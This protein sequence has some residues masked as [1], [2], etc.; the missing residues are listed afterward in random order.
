[1][2]LA[3]MGG[4]DWNDGMNRVG[5]KGKGESVWLSEF[6]VV[7][8]EEYAAVSPEQ[9]DAAWLRETANAFRSAI[10]KSAWDGEWYLRAFYDDGTPLG[11]RQN[12]EC[13]IDGISQAWAVLAGLDSARCRSAMNAAWNQL[14]DEKHGVIRLLAPPFT[15]EG[16]DPGYIR[17]YPRAFAKTARSIRT[18]RA[19]FCWR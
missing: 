8:A 13:R 19:G 12:A 5:A 1:M 11:S 17:G 7:C 18:R 2:G 3:L 14:V 16:R 6:M 15:S 4:G 9:S 10:E